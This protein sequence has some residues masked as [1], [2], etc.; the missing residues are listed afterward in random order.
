[1][2]AGKAVAVIWDMD[3]VIADTA[4][5]HFEAWQE[6]FQKRGVKF[7]RDDF[8]HVFG[9]RNDTIIRNTLGEAASKEG[10][11]NIAGEKERNYRQRV[12]QNI[13]P[14][15]GAIEL[16]KSLIQHEFKIALVSSSPMENVRLITEELGIYDCFQYIV[17]GR[18]VAEGKPSPQG[19]LLAAQRLGISPDRCIVIEDAVAGV[20]AAK[21]AG[22]CCLAVTNTHPRTSLVEADLIV[23]TLEAVSVGDLEQLLILSEGMSKRNE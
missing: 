19:F 5:Y 12:R 3:G 22:M 7:T 9:Q 6:V 16:I 14:L 13:K 21:Q 15:P 23:D 20:A 10:I 11:D 4:P 8:R 1:M 17:T 18:D 2:P